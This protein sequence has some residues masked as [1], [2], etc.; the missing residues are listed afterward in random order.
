MPPD[1]LE[2]KHTFDP[3]LFGK[4]LTR[5]QINTALK[6]GILKALRTYNRSINEAAKKYEAA[7]NRAAE[8]LQSDFNKL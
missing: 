8:K 6:N 7:R 1:F 5:H 3:V 2:T 4:L